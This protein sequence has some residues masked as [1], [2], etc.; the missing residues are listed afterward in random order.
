MAT[1]NDAPFVVSRQEA[2]AQGLLWYFLKPCV[3]GH[4]SRRMV[5]NKTCLECHRLRRAA[6]RLDSP[7][8]V[9]AQKA[10]SYLRHR[11]SVIA[12]AKAYQDAD[13]A[14]MHARQKAYRQANKEQLA[15][16]IK[17]WSK[18]NRP[19]LRAHERNRRDRKR[20]AEGSH[21]FAQI[22]AMAVR[23]RFLCANPVCRISIR[24]GWHEDHIM[25]IALGGSNWITNIQLL[26]PHCN[27]SKHARH[28][29][30]WAH[31]NG[32]LV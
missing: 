3:H 1:S 32:L 19:L 2:R 6:V 9:K 21:T 13:P 28:P 14:R 26:C 27:Q 11:D 22:Q 4:I 12:K 10:A 30:D 23:Q 31:M 17:E 29:I 8:L 18:A 15:A 24:N 16:T 5:S 25:P 20:G 7:E